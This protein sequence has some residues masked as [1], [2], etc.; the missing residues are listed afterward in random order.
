MT[1]LNAFG[2][3]F[4]P[5]SFEE[6]TCR[7]CEAKE[8]QIA[9]LKEAVDQL[10]FRL[11]KAEGLLTHRLRG[12]DAL[13]LTMVRDYFDSLKADPLDCSGEEMMPVRES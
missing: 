10:Q 1:S 9:V 3:G 5:E 11:S 13:T 8:A 7:E 12:S 2:G 4:S 6:Q